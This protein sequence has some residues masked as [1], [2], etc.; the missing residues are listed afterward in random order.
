MARS[1]QFD[2][3]DSFRFSVEV[4]DAAGQSVLSR[5]GFASC[6]FPSE[7][8]GEITYREGQY[9]DAMEKSA[10]LTVYNNITL[11]RGMTNDQDFY[12]W[13][14]A[15]KKHASNVRGSN[16]AFTANDTRPTDDASN[17]YRRTI[18]I[19]VLN[20]DSTPAKQYTLYNAHVASFQPGDNLDATSEAKI[21]S[22]L[23]LRYESYE[24]SA[25]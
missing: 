5:A 6:T 21:M 12:V 2:P 7:T 10:G 3:I 24:E 14:E 13:V 8:T 17:E 9:R 1:A 22:S 16:G 11:T 15:H 19:T 4:L 25:F 18:R 20:R 23:E